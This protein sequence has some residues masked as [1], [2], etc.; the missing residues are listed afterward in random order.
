MSEANAT[1]KL[2]NFKIRR[3]CSGAFSLV[4]LLVVISLISI[5]LGILV[6]ALSRGRAAARRTICQVRLKQ[7]AL[8]FEAYSSV[9]AGF[10]PHIDGRDRTERLSS[11]PTAEELANYYFGWVDVLPTFMN[12][13]PWRDYALY[14]KPGIDTIFQCPSAKIIKGADYNYPYDRIGYFS[15]AMNS[16]L[17]LDSDC[18]PPSY[19][20]QDQ[21]GRTNNM[22]SFLKAARIKRPTEVILLFDQLLDPKY[23]YNATTLNR[24]A[25]RHCGAY[26]REF[27]A[28]HKKG[29][30]GLGG[31]IL[32]SDYH[33][34]WKKSVWKK[35]WPEDLEVPPGDDTN[36]FPYQ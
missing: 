28:R 36:W 30:N 22:P 21:T 24:S 8:A 14:K 33:I 29:R 32:F 19:P 6:P 25:G 34:S 11:N 18:W 7:W 9:N 16:C 3:H 23:G 26:P 15:Y 31:F 35:D 27:S 5:L 17:E 2:E 4:E 12:L 1:T 10:Y 20:H 13:K